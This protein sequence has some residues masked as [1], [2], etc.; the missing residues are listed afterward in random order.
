MVEIHLTETDRIDWALK[1]FKLPHNITGPEVI[2]APPLAQK[3]GEAKP[4]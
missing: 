3:A 4:Q 1:S 2:C